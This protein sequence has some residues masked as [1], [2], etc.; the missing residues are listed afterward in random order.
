LLSPA[1]EEK[2]IEIWKDSSLLRYTG[3]VLTGTETPHKFGKMFYPNGT[4]YEGHFDN[5]IRSFNG[6]L[7]YKSSEEN[8]SW[9]V[10]G[11]WENNVPKSNTKCQ[12]TYIKKSE[13]DEIVKKYEYVGNIEIDRSKSNFEVLDINDF[14]KS[15]E[16]ELQESD[17]KYYGSFANN[18]RDGYG[19][20][21]YYLDKFGQKENRYF[22]GWKKDEMHGEGTFIYYDGTMFQG[23]FQNNIRKGKG[24]MCWPNGDRLSGEWTASSVAN[25]VFSKGSC[26]SCSV[27]HLFKMKLEIESA[28]K[29]K[30]NDGYMDMHYTSNNIIDASLYSVK[31]N[32]YKIAHEKIAQEEKELMAIQF[33][34]Q[35]KTVED[36]GKCINILLS[37]NGGL[38]E[39]KLYFKSLLNFFLTLFHKTYEAN[40][41]KMHRKNLELILHHA[42]EDFKSFLTFCNQEITEFFEQ[43]LG[44]MIENSKETSMKRGNF[45]VTKK[46]KAHLKSDLSE[47]ELNN[48]WEECKDSCESFIATF[49]HN[50]LCNTFFG[51]YEIVY[52]ERDNLINEKLNRIRNEPPERLSIPP[53]YL[54]AADGT[55]QAYVKSIEMLNDLV[56]EHTPSKKIKILSDVR[57]NLLIE[58]RKHRTNNRRIRKEKSGEYNEK[59]A[60]E[61]QGWQPGADDMTPIEVYIF[62][63]S[64]I[65]NHYAQFKYI[66]DWKDRSVQNLPVLHFISFYEGL[67][68]YIESSEFPESILTPD[69]T[70]QGSKQ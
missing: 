25:S 55:E 37:G 12:V 15:G 49:L 40:T 48:L 11:E 39:S 64:Q 8:I 10:E 52:K 1:V 13:N 2:T 66:S 60:L 41:D 23:T 14:H 34:K 62:I 5:G 58:L 70:T 16:G 26:E 61:D 57:E 56:T 19:V 45:I 50:K 21:I 51:L 7:S 53:E 69:P 22:G 44:A 31:W 29:K 47:I 6:K 35:L 54:P 65:Q 3:T 59:D 17:G 28:L 36:I 27:A 68:S 32:H 9:T 42:I 33:C 24:T 38:D 67:I 43:L 30:I 46:I 63:K 18:M 4:I 20:Q